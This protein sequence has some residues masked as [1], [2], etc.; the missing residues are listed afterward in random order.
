MKLAT[1]LSVCFWLTVA[2]AAQ[3]TEKSWLDAR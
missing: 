2:V 1:A 3:S